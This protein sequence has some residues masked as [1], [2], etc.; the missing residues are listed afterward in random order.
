Q[1]CRVRIIS[2][3]QKEAYMQLS[4][5]YPLQ[6][7]IN[8]KILRPMLIHSFT[9]GYPYTESGFCDPTGYY[10]GRNSSGGIILFD[11]W[12]RSRSRT[13]SSMTIVGGSGSGKSTS[14][15]HIIYS[16]IARGT[17]ILIIDLEGEYK[18]ICLSELINGKWIDVAGGRGGVINPLQIRPAP[19]DDDEANL[20]DVSD[21][22]IHLKTLQMFFSL[23]LPEL[24]SIQKALLERS[25]IQLYE[26]FGINWYTNINDLKNTDFPTIGDLY[27]LI[28][29][30][31]EDDN[32]KQ[33]YETLALLL[34]SAAKGADRGLWNGHTSIDSNSRCICLD[35]KA[36]ATIGG[37]VL[38]AQYFN[39]LSWCWQEISKNKTERIMLIADE[40]WSLIDPKCPQSLEFL[41]NAEKRARKYEGSIVVAS[42]EITDF[43]DPQIKLYGQAVLDIPT[44]KFIFGTASKSL[45]ELVETFNLNEEQRRILE[46]QQ[47]GI[48]LMTVGAQKTKVE[49]SF[50][51]ERLAMFGKGGGR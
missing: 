28:G 31:P 2:Q 33:D 47:K 16:E 46:K 23:Y 5:T 10:L 25:L 4:P 3:E 43:L 37:N 50:S 48:A 12:I 44:I 51:E 20:S 1:G 36:V 24:T 26:N 19:R 45:M 38:A 6:E 8:R 15:K 30:I 18:E 42:Q 7:T 11:P 14:I 34:E 17:K 49:F 9:G 41:R 21:M 27:E 22:S 13:N 35:T 40:C 29:N 32:N 39:I